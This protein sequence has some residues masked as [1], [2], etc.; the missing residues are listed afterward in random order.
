SHIFL[1]RP[2]SRVN[3]YI[4][5]VNDDV[6]QDEGDGNDQCRTLNNADPGVGNAIDKHSAHALKV[7]DDLN[8]HRATDEVAHAQ[9]QHGHWS[10][11]R[12]AQHVA[13]NYNAAWNSRTNSRANVI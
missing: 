9:A 11:E 5:Y 4:K 2:N 1:H 10:N 12:V 3:Q 13:G 6:D 7:E 8:D